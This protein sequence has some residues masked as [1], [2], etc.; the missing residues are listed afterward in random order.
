MRTI[1]IVPFTGAIDIRVDTRAVHNEQRAAAKN[2]A[3][4]TAVVPVAAPSGNR[5]SPRPGRPDA[6]F[7]VQLNATATHA[8]QT[9]PLRRAQPSDAVTRYRIAGDTSATSTPVRFY[10]TA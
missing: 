10:R 3:A 9:R 1:G 7:V 8:P 4:S 5:A 2:A 6:A